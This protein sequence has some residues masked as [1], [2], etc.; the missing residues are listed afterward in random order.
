[1]GK[2]PKRTYTSAAS[3]DDAA[4]TEGL[5]FE[6]DDVEFTCHGRISAFDLAE[7]AGPVADAG[8]ADTADPAVLRILTDFLRVV[9]GDKTYAAFTRHRRVHKTPDE[10]VQ[11]ILFDI[12]EDA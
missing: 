11:Q 4:S 2:R 9:L 3:K 1:M 12:I 5:T 7:F 10:V 6:L 8:N